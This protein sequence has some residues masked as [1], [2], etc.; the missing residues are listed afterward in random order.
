M[1][2]IPYGFS[3]GVPCRHNQTTTVDSSCSSEGSRPI[4]A[5]WALLAL[6]DGCQQ[7]Y[8]QTQGGEPCSP[9]RKSHS[10]PALVAGSAGAEAVR[11]LE[12]SAPG[13]AT[14]DPGHLDG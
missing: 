14:R 5:A 6:A 13:Q 3:P 7:C 8:H 11:T 4:V 9:L 10:P 12:E 2:G 1:V